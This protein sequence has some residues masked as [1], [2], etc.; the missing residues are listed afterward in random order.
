MN[1]LIRRN[2]PFVS[3]PLSVNVAPP[4]PPIA[5]VMVKFQ[6]ILQPAF[7]SL[8]SIFGNG[9]PKTKPG[10]LPVSLSSCQLFASSV[11]GLSSSARAPVHGATSQAANTAA[12]RANVTFIDASLGRR[13]AR[14]AGFRA[15][16]VGLS[17]SA[18]RQPCRLAFHGGPAA[19]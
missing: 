8:L 17:S 7:G 5:P 9:C 6:A 18:H 16:S 4:P 2:C 10:I 15:F 12:H 11:H 1:A 14:R 19:E 13:L 3:T